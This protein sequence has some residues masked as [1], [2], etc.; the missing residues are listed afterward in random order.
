MGY[1]HSP[2]GTYF[3][4]KS[5][6]LAA[7]EFSEKYD[8]IIIMAETS[9][10]ESFQICCNKLCFF[11]F[12]TFNPSLSP[13]SLLFHSC[14]F[15]T[16]E[17]PLKF[18]HFFHDV[19]FYFT[20]RQLQVTQTLD[21]GAVTLYSR[22]N[23]NQGKLNPWWKPLSVFAELWWNESVFLFSIRFGNIEC[24]KCWLNRRNS[25][26]FEL[27]STSNIILFNTIEIF[28]SCSL[29]SCLK[30]EIYISISVS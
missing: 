10:P 27:F 23:I 6:L 16:L 13:G 25:F 26:S 2:R 20:Q 12:I 18:F 3:Q 21:L 17:R 4:T 11:C 29:F 22:G 30:P 28:S 7:W 8:A 19:L 14:F 9:V 1:T 5:L 24:E 15:S